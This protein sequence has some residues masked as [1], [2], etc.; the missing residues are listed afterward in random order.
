MQQFLTSFEPDDVVAAVTCNS[1]IAK[2]L[3]V[4]SIAGVWIKNWDFR[5]ELVEF[6]EFVRIVRA[7]SVCLNSF[8]GLIS[9]TSAGFRLL[10]SAVAS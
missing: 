1:V 7:G 4:L 10:R 8:P 9:G 5:S 2:V 6:L 3:I